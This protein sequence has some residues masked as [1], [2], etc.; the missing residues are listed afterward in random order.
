MRKPKGTPWLKSNWDG[1]RKAQHKDFEKLW[2]RGGKDGTVRS[3]TG[4]EFVVTVE[5]YPIE[6]KWSWSHCGLALLAYRRG[7]KVITDDFWFPPHALT[8]IDQLGS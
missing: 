6:Q 7:M 4:T 1:F 8:L 5:R 3:R 2:A